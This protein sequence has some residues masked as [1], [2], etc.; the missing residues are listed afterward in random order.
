MPGSGLQHAQGGLASVSV[1]MHLLSPD[2]GSRLP[3]LP[4]H[5]CPARAAVGRSHRPKRVSLPHMEQN[6]RRVA[7]SRTAKQKEQAAVWQ[8]CP[9]LPPKYTKSNLGHEAKKKKKA[10]WGSQ[11]QARK[12]RP[13]CVFDVLTYLLHFERNK[14]FN[15][16]IR[17]TENDSGPFWGLHLKNMTDV[18]R[19]TVVLLREVF[20]FVVSFDGIVLVKRN[21]YIHISAH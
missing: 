5:I 4:P 13:W 10:W 1:G 12:C 3:T 16:R 21:K 20:I 19:R 8:R 6:P 2:T 7:I 18:S 15:R 17:R 14:L 11:M 9:Y